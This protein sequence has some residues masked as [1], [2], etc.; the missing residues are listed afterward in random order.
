MIHNKIQIN[1]GWED[2]KYVNHIINNHKKKH[3]KNMK[4]TWNKH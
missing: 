4:M 2:C 3:N 1:K